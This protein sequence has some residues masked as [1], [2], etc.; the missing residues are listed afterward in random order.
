[1][2]SANN[3]KASA[4]HRSGSR[5]THVHAGSTVTVLVGEDCHDEFMPLECQS[6]ANIVLGG[7][8]CKVCKADGACL[9]EYCQQPIKKTRAEDLGEKARTKR[10]SRCGQC[11]VVVY[12]NAIC[13]RC[14]WKQHKKRCAGVDMRTVSTANRCSCEACK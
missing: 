7:G 11:R 13:Q 1:M 5:I 9:C 10:G 6:C 2:A 14:D 8:F 3:T 4:G 12:C